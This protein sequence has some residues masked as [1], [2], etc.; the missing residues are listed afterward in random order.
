MILINYLEIHWLLLAVVPTSII[1]M[2]FTVRL[3]EKPIKKK[4]SLVNPYS[5]M[6]KEVK[7]FNKNLKT[8]ALITFFFGMM[9]TIVYFFAPAVSYARGGSLVSSALLILAYSIPS[10]FGEK[11]GIFADKIKYKGYFLSLSSLFLVLLVLAFSPNYYL[12][13]ASMFIAGMTFELTV[14]TNKGFMARNSDYERIG[15]IDGALNGI[16]SLGSIIGPV[17][18]GLLLEAFAPMNSYIFVAGL[19][20]FMMILLYKKKE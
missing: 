17:I 1:A 18:F 20:L 2:F 4:K 6:I 9:N 3:K 10:L 14:L 8:L 16:G 7:G 15:E 12:L 13:L 5:K 19:S 11:L